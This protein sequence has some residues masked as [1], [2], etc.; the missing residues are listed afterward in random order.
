MITA[1][2]I[3]NEQYWMNSKSNNDESRIMKSPKS[4]ISASRPV[5]MQAY[6][7]TANGMSPDNFLSNNRQN[8]AMPP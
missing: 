6:P 1:S 7:E 4:Y 2:R 5:H 3:D 8:N